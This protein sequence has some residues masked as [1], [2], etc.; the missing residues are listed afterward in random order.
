MEG[1]AIVRESV[2]PAWIDDPA[3]GNE[4]HKYYEKH[5]VTLYPDV[6]F[7]AHHWALAVDLNRC[8]GCSTCVIACQAENN[9]PVVGKEEV[10][11]R[12]IMHWMRIDRYY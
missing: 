12:R 1:R 8:T 5:K 4:L 10:Q 9:V 2:L 7:E 11:R 3:S 6:E